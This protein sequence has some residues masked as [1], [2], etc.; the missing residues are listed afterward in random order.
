EKDATAVYAYQLLT[1]FPPRR[2]IP[3]QRGSVAIANDGRSYEEANWARLSPT[4]RTVHNRLRQ[5]R[6]MPTIPPPEIDLYVPPERSRSEFRA[7]SHSSRGPFVSV[8]KLLFEFF[9]GT[10]NAN[11]EWSCRKVFR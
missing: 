6:G 4:F 11:L 10:A 8:A 1:D 5:L 9:T 3:A 2:R 7:P